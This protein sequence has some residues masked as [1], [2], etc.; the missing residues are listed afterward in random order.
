[1]LNC[2]LIPVHEHLPPWCCRRRRGHV[3]HTYTDRVI[4]FATVWGRVRLSRWECTQQPLEGSEVIY[5]HAERGGSGQGTNA[6]GFFLRTQVQI[7]VHKGVFVQLYRLHNHCISAGSRIIGLV[8]M[9]LRS[10]SCFR[11]I[12]TLFFILIWIYLYLFWNVFYFTFIF[13]W[14]KTWIIKLVGILK[15]DKKKKSEKFGGNCE[16]NIIIYLVNSNI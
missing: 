1:M 13:V 11:I 7:D 6:C 9:T 8:V 5:W 16:K 10:E 15:N 3:T 12:E 2:C 4:F 14:Y